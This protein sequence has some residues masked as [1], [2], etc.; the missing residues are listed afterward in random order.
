MVIKTSRQGSVVPQARSSIVG[1][2]DAPEG[3]W[4]WI[5]YLVITDEAGT[6]SCGGSILTEEWVLTAAHCVDPNDNPI[7][8]RSYVRLG[9]HSLN[10]PSVFRRTIS[11]IVSHPQYKKQRSELLH[12]IALVKLSIKVSFSSLVEPMSLPKPSDAFGPKSECW[13]AGWGNVGNDVKLSGNRTLQ[14]L[15]L[16]IVRRLTCKKK[17]PGFTDNMMCAGSLDGG[18]D[19]C[20][21]DSGGP[22]VCRS[23]GEFVQRD[24]RCRQQTMG[25]EVFG[26]ERTVD[27]VEDIPATWQCW[28]C[29]FFPDGTWPAVCRWALRQHEAL[30][31]PTPNTHR[32]S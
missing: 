3:S 16:P 13:I 27:S 21:G 30:D 5:A 7:P 9:I 6:F 14:E 23:S 15:R 28:H 4:P 20:Q 1:G 32:R 26:V 25:V 12:D 17:F 24:L 10:E 8:D 2:K 18:K 29:Y 22:L 31:G 11:R 19:S